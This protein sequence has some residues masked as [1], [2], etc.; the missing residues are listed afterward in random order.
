M[1]TFEKIFWAMTLAM[2]LLLFGHWHNAYNKP[3]F[4]QSIEERFEELDEVE[5]EEILRDAKRI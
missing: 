5:K 1:T 2:A 3:D 4:K